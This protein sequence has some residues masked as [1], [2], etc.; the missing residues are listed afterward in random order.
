MGVA[1]CHKPSVVDLLPDN[2][3]ASHHALPSGIDVRCVIDQRKRGLEARC[4]RVGVNCG[5]TQAVLSDRPRGD[6][7]ELDQDLWG[8]M[9]HQGSLQLRF[10]CDN[11]WR[12]FLGSSDYLKRYQTVRQNCYCQNVANRWTWGENRP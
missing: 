8:S 9:Q 10:E 1:D 3:E 6:A 11:H 5:E 12:S 7:A 2:A 4:Q